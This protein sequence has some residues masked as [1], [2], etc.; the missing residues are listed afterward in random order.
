MLVDFDKGPGQIDVGSF[1]SAVQC[2]DR[3][4]EKPAHS[5]CMYPRIICRLFAFGLNKKVEV[6]WF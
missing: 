5:F 3:V 1:A 6:A 4:F 2:A